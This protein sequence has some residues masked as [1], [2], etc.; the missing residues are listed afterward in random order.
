MPARSITLF[1][2]SLALNATLSGQTLVSSTAPKPPATPTHEVTDEYF[3]TRIVDSYRWLEDLKSPEV[4][5]WMKAQND[6]TRAVL[7]RIPG[8]E[9]L[10]VRIAQLDDTGVR[11]S[12]FQSYG[13]RWFYLKR[14]PGQDNQRLYTRDGSNATER[15]LLD[16]ETLTANGVHYSIDYYTPSP[17]GKL[18]AVG[19]APGG[20]ENA[21]LHVLDAATGKELGEHID[22]AQFGAIAWLPDNRSFFYNRLRKLGPDEPFSATA[23]LLR[24]RWQRVTSHLS[25]CPSDRSM[26]SRSMPMACRT[27]SQF[28]LP[29]L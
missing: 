28:M 3:G 1:V 11:V 24:F 19:I 7:D 12:S 21:V 27:S 14:S 13:G 6:Y 16:P 18:V 9:K 2:L 17:V 10:R 15:L 22:R 29:K 5:A 8:R 23:S 25:P 20:S 4:S 26:P